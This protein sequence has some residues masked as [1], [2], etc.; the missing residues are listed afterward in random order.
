MPSKPKAKSSGLKNAANPPTQQV[1]SA[2]TQSTG[3]YNNAKSIPKQSVAVAKDQQDP[4]Q[5][6][7]TK[8]I[9]PPQ[10]PAPGFTDAAN[11]A[12][13]VN[14][15]KQKRRLKEAAKRAAA[16]QHDA[17]VPMQEHGVASHSM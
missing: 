15:K 10:Q 4:V 12:P 7:P 14:R 11:I 6:L 8:P 9:S 2:G 3:P 16:D 13:G 5:S 1:P 17:A